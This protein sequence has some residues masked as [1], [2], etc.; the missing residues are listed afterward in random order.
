MISAGRALR[1]HGLK[2]G[3]ILRS[4]CSEEFLKDSLRPGVTVYLSLLEQGGR[5]KRIVLEKVLFG[6]KMIVYFQGYSDRNA[7]EELLP[8]DLSV[9]GDEPLDLRG[10]TAYSRENGEGG[11]QSR[12]YREQWCSKS[13]GDSG[14]RKL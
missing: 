1:P 13:F 5:G 9:E 10:F 4:D 11:G 6:K 8:F 7:I 3:A 12:L 14:K 2:G